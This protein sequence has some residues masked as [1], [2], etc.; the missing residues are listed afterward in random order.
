EKADLSQEELDHVTVNSSTA[1]ALVIQEISDGSSFAPSEVPVDLKER[2][3]PED[4]WTPSYSVTSQGSLSS[5]VEPELAPSANIMADTVSQPPTT[6]ETAE[7]LPVTI[8][9]VQPV[10]PSSVEAEG[11]K[12]PTVEPVADQNKKSKS[13]G[14]RLSTLD[15]NTTIDESLTSSDAAVP[16]TGR[17][18]LESTASSRFFPGGW[19]SP[20]KTVDETRASLEVAKGE[21]TAVKI[22][23]AR[24]PSIDEGPS[25][26]APSPDVETSKTPLSANSEQ[27]SKWCVIM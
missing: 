15:E 12:F 6:H 5:A 16:P 7:E 11:E 3:H 1:S 20:S 26:S 17:S 22:A 21:F 14:L 24:N 23:S 18:R 25:E 8:E 27:K 2:V 4:S 13:P 10:L 19:F 9:V